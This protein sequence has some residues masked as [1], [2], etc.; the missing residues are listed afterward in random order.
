MNNNMTIHSHE[1][2]TYAIEAGRFNPAYA[3]EFLS[4][5][6]LRMQVAMIKQQKLIDSLLPK[7]MIKEWGEK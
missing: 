7:E 3:I 5:E 4:G 6:I 2:I 1:D